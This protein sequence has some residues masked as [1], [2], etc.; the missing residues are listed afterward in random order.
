MNE[1]PVIVLNPNENK[2]DGEKIPLNF[3]MTAHAYHV[4]MEYVEPSGF[5]SVLII[6]HSAGGRCLSTIQ[7]QCSGSFYKI[8]KK[9]AYTDSFV[10]PKS[11]LNQE[12]QEFMKNNAVH[13]LASDLPLGTPM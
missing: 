1:Y 4:W 2:V 5:E 3:S 13:Y 9:I 12:Q 6:A 11:E 8:V 10:I 7:K